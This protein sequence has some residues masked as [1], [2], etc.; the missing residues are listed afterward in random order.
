[1]VESEKCNI[2]EVLLDKDFKITVMNMIKGLREN[3]NESFNE[4][5]KTTKKQ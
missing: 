4:V 1:M 2:A 5:C 3:M